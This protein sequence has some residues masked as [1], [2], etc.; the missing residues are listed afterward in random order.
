MRP[1]YV[2]PMRRWVVLLLGAALV[3]LASLYLPWQTATC[4]QGCASVPVVGGGDLGKALSANLSI[5]GWSSAAGGA[6]ALAALA[7]AAMAAAAL[8]RPGQGSRLPL[9]LCAL[10][11]GYFALAVAVET[12]ST[13]RQ[14]EAAL[15]MSDFH[16]GYGAYLGIAAAIVA[17]VSAGAMRRRDLAQIRPRS[18]LATTV[19]GVG[20]LVSFLLPWG[21][22]F[23][24]IAAPAAIVA[25][26]L[27]VC[28]AASPANRLVLSTAALLFTGA[29][30]STFDN[31]GS[32]AYGAWI[33]LG[34]AIGLVAVAVAS[35]NGLPTHE[36]PRG[37]V[38]AAIGAAGLLIAG[39]FLPWQQQCYEK[40]ADFGPGSGRCIST[41]GWASS[42]GATAALLAIGLVILLVAPRRF[43]SP[44]TLGAGIALLIAT[45]GFQLENRSA[46]GIHLE[47]GSG[48][49]IGFVAA[50]LLLALTVVGLRPRKVGLRLAPIA[51]C[52]AYLG[53]VVVPWW[54]VLPH[55]VQASLTFA[56]LSWP[57]IAGVL[58]AVWLVQLWAARAAAGAEWLVIVPLG[59]LSL[60][61]LDLTRL[62]GDGITWGR[63]IVVSLCLLLGAFGWFEQQDGL[64]NARIPTFLRFDRL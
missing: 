33:G 50:G 64:E 42:L 11:M 27:T 34:I 28:L 52:V 38:L 57:T 8:I 37:R 40:S 10:L 35:R 13:G 56:E 60:A 1:V 26:A 41:N 9:G 53:V 21:A 45:A 16:Y 20:L 62:R 12:R 6:S 39:L 30:F 25:A 49:M 3:L 54:A 29:A 4:G 18:A 44:A 24:G 47:F 59:M 36:S 5:Q 43:L 46:D 63:G 22:S 23:L 31:L 14:R 61:A 51:A 48:A 58:L 2:C 7:L 17:L 32:R 19:L 15:S 55:G